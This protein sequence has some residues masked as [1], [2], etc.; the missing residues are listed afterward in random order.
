M[1]QLFVKKAWPCLAFVA[2]LLFPG[3]SV[4]AQA[5]EQGKESLSMTQMQWMNKPAHFEMKD[6]VLEIEALKGS[7]FFNNP[8]DGSVK[9]TA[10]YFYREIEGD[11]VAYAQ[12]EPDFSAQWN[13]VSLLL[14]LDASHWIKFAYENSDATGP[15]IVTVVTKG[16]SDDANGVVL[17]DQSKLWLALV[18]KGHI[19]AMHWSLDGKHYTMARLSALGDQEKVKIG[20]EVQSPVGTSAMHRIHDFYI[21]KKTVANLRNL[22]AQP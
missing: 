1:A 16:Q 2:L 9:A 21:E 19:Y 14:Y 18:R 20:F 13:A 11:F 10:P 3:S 4:K 12:V 15:S 7:D 5:V 22:N 6:G 17:K 8:E